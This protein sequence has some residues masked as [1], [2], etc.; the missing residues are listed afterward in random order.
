MLRSTDALFRHTILADNDVS[1][2]T[3][4]PR[5]TPA[6]VKLTVICV[7]NVAKVTCNTPNNVSIVLATELNSNIFLWTSLKNL[8]ENEYRSAYNDVLLAG[9][10]S[11]NIDKYVCRTLY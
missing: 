9:F 1:K 7:E 10:T 4:I 2:T 11:N 6:N 8:N 3:L 5:T